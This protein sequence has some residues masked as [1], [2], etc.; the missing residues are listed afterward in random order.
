MRACSFANAGASLLAVALCIVAACSSDGTSSASDAGAADA[1]TAAD[2]SNAKLPSCVTEGFQ[3]QPKGCNTGFE[4][5]NGYDCGSEN[6]SCC[7]KSV[8]PLDASTSTDARAL[9]A[10]ASD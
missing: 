1:S 4:P 7:G 9:D 5:L 3:C 6:A 8:A 2:G 10:G